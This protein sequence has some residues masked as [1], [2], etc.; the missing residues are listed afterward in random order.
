[1]K[2]PQ[3]SSTPLVAAL[4]LVVCLALLTSGESGVLMYTLLFLL[5]CVLQT[6]QEVLSVPF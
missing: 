1:M 4:C 5:G 6:S 2:L 3:N